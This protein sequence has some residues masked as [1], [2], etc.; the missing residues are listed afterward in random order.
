MK[1]IF[2]PLFLFFEIISNVPS[3]FYTKPS[4]ILA[5]IFNPKPKL[6]FILDLCRLL[7][8]ELV[9]TFLKFYSYSEPIPIPESLTYNLIK[10]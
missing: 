7:P 10:G 9:K 8:I 2:V 6:F 4:T 3:F 1:Y 5:E